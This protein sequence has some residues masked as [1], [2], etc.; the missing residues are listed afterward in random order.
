MSFFHGLQIEIDGTNKTLDVLAQ[1][2]RTVPASEAAAW[3][4]LGDATGTHP[5]ASDR[6]VAVPIRLDY[7]PGVALSEGEHR[8]KFFVD[9]DLAGEANGGR[10]HFNLYIE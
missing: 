6:T 8:I 7:L 5:L 2:A 10:I 9:Q 4:I 1:I 3:S